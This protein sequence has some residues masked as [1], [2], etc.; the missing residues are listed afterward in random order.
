MRRLKDPES[1]APGSIMPAFAGLS[2]AELTDLTKY[3]I[4]LK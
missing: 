3:L 4:T 2:E 1:V